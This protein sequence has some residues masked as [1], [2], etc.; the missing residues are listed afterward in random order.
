M[1]FIFIFIFVFH[2]LFLNSSV[3]AYDGVDWLPQDKKYL[4]K[5]HSKPILEDQWDGFNFTGVFKA[6]ACYG[7][8]NLKDT[9]IYTTLYPC[10]E[11]A[12]LIVQ[13]GIKKVIY[14]EAE[15][16]DAFNEFI[17]IL[18][19]HIDLNSENGEE[20]AIRETFNV[21]DEDGSGEIDVIELQHAMIDMGVGQDSE[22]NGG[23]SMRT[24]KEL[25]IH[26]DKEGEGS[27]SY[28]QFKAALATV[29]KVSP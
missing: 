27:I 18:Q 23:L 21:F 20:Q 8:K 10:N 7:S 19:E 26:I 12:K 15:A 9:I 6:R 24:A 14:L 25:M 13:S 11:C 17:G 5:K 29:A 22:G 1:K 16:A 28:D 3:S 4:N 2:M